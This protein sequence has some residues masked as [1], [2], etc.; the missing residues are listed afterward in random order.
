VP[1]AE[2]EV[3]CIPHAADGSQPFFVVGGYDQGGWFAPMAMEEP[4]LGIDVPP[5]ALGDSLDGTKPEDLH[6]IVGVVF[7]NPDGS[8]VVVDWSNEEGKSQQT[9][10]RYNLT[11]WKRAGGGNSADLRQWTI[12]LGQ[13]VVVGHLWAVGMSNKMR[14]CGS[15]AY[16]MLEEGPPKA[17]YFE[18]LAIAPKAILQAGSARKA[19]DDLE[20]RLEKALD[21]NRQLKT[22]TK[23][24]GNQ[25]TELESR[26][27]LAVQGLSA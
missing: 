7:L 19:V 18:A 23:C 5:E 12:R 3:A 13:T 9:K 24:L 21:E 20:D 17:A 15:V 14:V 16:V 1:E 26:I 22:A 8:D 27:K 6:P 2:F 10:L 4:G 25:V 11:N